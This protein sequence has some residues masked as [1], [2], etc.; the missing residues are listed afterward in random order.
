MEILV[1]KN[2]VFCSCYDAC[3]FSKSTKEQGS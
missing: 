3:S 1:T 2:V